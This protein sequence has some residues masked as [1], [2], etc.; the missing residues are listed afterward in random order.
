MDT[1][2]TADTNLI[3]ANVKRERIGLLLFFL[4][5]FCS[6]IGALPMILASYG[7]QL[8]TPVRL[9]QILMLFGPA[10]AAVLCT[11]LNEGRTGLRDLFGRLL[12]WRVNP[13][14]YALALIVPPLVFFIALIFSNRIAGTTI[15][16]PAPSYVLSSFLSALGGY[17]LLN[18]EELAWRGYA[19][20]RLTSRIGL[21][22]ATVV[23]GVLWTVFHLP[24]FWMKG[25]HPAGFSFPVFTAMVMAITFLFSGAYYASGTSILIVHLMHQSVNAGVEALRVYPKAAHSITPMMTATALLMAVAIP[26]LVLARKRVAAG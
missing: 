6:W 2:I 5:L 8:S 14:W 17:L 11:W 19:L 24:L 3:S 13:G 7:K 4:L 16:F 9:L 26:L 20:P 15:P 22:P 18:T 23:I 10:L 12:R 21:I 25:G 1:S